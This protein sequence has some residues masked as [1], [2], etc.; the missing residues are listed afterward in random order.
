VLVASASALAIASVFTVGAASPSAAS[1]SVA[2]PIPASTGAIHGPLVT[3]AQPPPT[4]ADC[5]KQFQLRCYAPFQYAKAYDLNAL[6]KSGINGAGRTIALV[7]SFGSPTIRQD[8]K[9][10]DKAFGLPAPKLT[11]V[12]PAGP[13]PPWNPNNSDMV[14]WG[15]ETT[16]DVEWAHAIAPDANLL[17]VETPVSETEGVQGFPQMMQSEKFIIDHGLVDVISQ[18]FGA[19]ENTFPNKQALLDLRFAFKDALAH[20]VTVL[21]ASGD[22]GA[23]DFELD[24]TTLYPMRVNSWP[25]SDPLVTSVGGTQLTLN[26]RGDRLGPDIVWNDGFGAGGGGMSQVFSRPD[27][28]NSVK[29]VVGTVRGTPDIS[30]SAS[31]VG[32]CLVFMSVP[33]VAP[34]WYIFGG[35]SEAS[36]LMAG[37]VAMADQAAG[38]RLGWLNS[39]LYQLGSHGGFAAA[40][41]GIVD[42][43]I[44]N[45]TFG[46]V[47]GFQALRGYDLA[48]GL[49]TV[50]GWRLVHALANGD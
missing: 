46:G 35:T 27:F 1:H 3:G 26:A 28:Q 17:L 12:T 5:L 14:M 50:D 22:T 38:H 21:G 7:D 32:G 42:I 33:G 44:G 4:T 24:L 9:V 20:H 23:T 13:P 25:S 47:A 15:E 18:S 36:P 41:H 43:L 39:T 16:L 49:G 8:L 11:I 37:I 34:G 19:T 2:R 10:F 45:N 31:V 29:N 40:K 48:S 30:M 6:Y